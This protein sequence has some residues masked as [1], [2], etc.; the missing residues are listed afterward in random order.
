MDL[1][2]IF[3]SLLKQVFISGK[4]RCPGVVPSAVH[5][6]FVHWPRGPTCSETTHH[7]PPG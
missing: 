7:R 4:D 2:W 5:P 1:T 6:G 3:D